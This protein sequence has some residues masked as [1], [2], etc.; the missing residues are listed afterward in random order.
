MMRA[1][2]LVFMALSLCAMVA[3]DAYSAN[4][5]AP[6]F[7]QLGRADGLSQAYVLAMAEDHQG[8]L[9]FGTQDGLNRYDGNEFLTFLSDDTK[10]NSILGEKVEDIAIDLDGHIW[11]ATDKS[12]TVLDR[13]SYSATNYT[14]DATASYAMTPTRLR[15]V[16][17]DSDNAVWFGGKDTTLGKLDPDTGEMQ[18]FNLAVSD[19][20]LAQSI[21]DIVAAPEGK[22]WIASDIGLLLFSEAM[23]IEQRFAR[24]SNPQTNI[25]FDGVNVVLTDSRGQVWAGVSD[26]Q[27][28]ESG[29]T[30]LV[31]I[32]DTTNSQIRQW[33]A[34]ATSA[35]TLPSETEV[36]SI[37][38]DSEGIVWLGQYSGLSRYDV[39]Q[40]ELI[41]LQP[42]ANDIS[43]LAHETV[44]SILVDS[45]GVMWIGT[46]GG[47][48][49]FA[50][51]SLNMRRYVE[52]TSN[53]PGE[54]HS[55][56][57]TSFEELP[58]GEILLTTLDRGLSVFDNTTGIF[59]R[60]GERWP[61]VAPL[62]SS[63]LTSLHVD[64]AGDV[65]VGSRA[66][67]LNRVSLEDGSVKVYRRD[68][69]DSS[70]LPSDKIAGIV[71]GDDGKIWVATMGGGVA[72]LDPVSDRIE[73]WQ[74]AVNDNSTI[75]SDYILVVA[76]DSLGMMWVGHYGAGMDQI[77]PVSG[78]VTRVSKGTPLEQAEVSAIVEDARGDL[79]IT[80]QD[81]GLWR[82]SFEQRRQGVFELDSFSERA[83]L[84]TSAIYSAA[85]GA[86][87]NLWMGT[88]LGLTRVDTEFA[89]VTNFRSSEGV[90]SGEFNFGAAFSAAD[91]RMYFGADVGF[92]AFYPDV[93][94][95]N[96]RAPTAV[97]TAISVVNESQP[98]AVVNNADEPLT[99]GHRDYAIE[100]S[101]AAM[102]FTDPGLHR[103]RYWLEGLE[104]S[105]QD[106]GDRRRVSY[107]NLSPGR[108]KFKAMVTNNNG[109]WSHNA[110]EREF[111]IKPAPW[112]S[113]YAY[114]LYAVALALLV[115][116]LLRSHAARLRE[117]AAESYAD[118]LASINSTLTDE[119]AVRREKEI[120]LQ[121]QK[122]RAETYFNVA[123]AILLTLDE[124]GAVI[125]INHKG[126]KI[127]GR[128]ADEICGEPW[129]SFVPD[130]WKTAVQTEVLSLLGSERLF[131]GDYFEFPLLDIDGRENL[132]AWNCKRLSTAETGTAVFCS[133][134]DVTRVRTLEKQMRLHEKMN[135]IGTLA[136]G[137]AHDFNNILQAIY[138]FT[139]L[140]LERL[141]PTDEKAIYLQQVVKGADRARNLVKR[142]LTFSNQKEY[143]LEPIDLLPVVREALALLRGSLPS[144]V[145]IVSNL[146]DQRISVE[147]DPTRI[148]QIIMNLGTNAGQSMNR[149]GGRMNVSLQ[150]V[151]INEDSM[152]EN[153]ALRTGRYMHLAVTD[154]GS[155]MTAD[156]LD[157]IF[158][159]F[160]TTKE[161]NENTGL[162]LT[163]VHG[164]VQ[165]HG[166][167]IEVES[168][169]GQGTTFNVYFPVSAESVQSVAR[170]NQTIFAG[171]ETVLIV[172]DES[173]VLTVTSKMLARQ[174]YT[175]I[176]VSTGEEAIDSVE[177]KG[178]ELDLLITDETMPK[179][180]G[181]QLIMEARERLPNLPVLVISGKLAP[182]S[183]ATPNTW[184]LQKPF[185][186]G[187]LARTVR[188]VLD[189]RVIPDM[190]S[191]DVDQFGG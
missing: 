165:S 172:D 23:G 184:F 73:R 89:V 56:R 94:R 111:V 110:V 28:N 129:L 35:I 169:P 177:S 91:G 105:W 1:C 126:C 32:I 106:A 150:P 113:P 174:G 176:A 151:D 55:N 163:V 54:L 144:T 122:E 37:Y 139:T 30:P 167:H 188:D 67:G 19:D 153:S 86:D 4:S 182:K 42:E 13:Y 70:S 114:L 148:H 58:S 117:R 14:G 81:L 45:S 173:W 64:D 79:W 116:V 48:S 186:A 27:E 24:T 191:S 93:I 185:T 136:G 119:V 80:T 125:R 158:D 102:D 168:T 40:N 124:N 171:D 5:I 145:E 180:T 31:A 57:I 60:F 112:M 103:Y 53:E 41:T 26:R 15:T 95:N 68:P 59:Q 121:Q 154:S 2:Y 107:T 25:G 72:R 159:P 189:G 115:V 88:G 138:G 141:H 29:D 82:W 140:A 123:D 7:K 137:I 74:S 149:T 97:L 3:S 52:S 36:L 90:L 179:M 20:I 39:N 157:H 162:G 76:N 131:S 71:Q 85:L 128:S 146:C 8:F 21:N 101:V 38:E 155:G 18:F 62:S 142:I 46:F 164:I 43:S 99:L 135:A 120:A 84:E 187:E 66:R 9:W 92:N 6:R 143:D 152:P 130:E 98:M 17:V 175:V 96:E 75:G 44:S 132:I 63:R 61:N 33:S 22:L 181:S 190:P 78:K 166:G 50:A 87:G 49:Y 108:Y 65:W 133:G 109:M 161:T 83:G 16:F 100:F 127:L 118:E 47:A 69:N 34:A 51:N 104:D 134:L 147:A 156:T 10:P 170:P 11:V 183:V 160:F 178:A 12:L 77:D